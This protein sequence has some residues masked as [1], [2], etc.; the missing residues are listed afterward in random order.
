MTVGVAIWLICNVTQQ[1]LLTVLEPRTQG[2]FLLGA[3]TEVPSLSERI[4]KRAQVSLFSRP[5]ISYQRPKQR[6][7]WSTRRKT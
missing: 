2:F 1:S 5:F 3:R 4:R 6:K 7:R